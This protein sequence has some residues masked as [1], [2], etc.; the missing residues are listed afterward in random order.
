MY[1]NNENW[2]RKWMIM[3]ILSIRQYYFRLPVCVSDIYRMNLGWVDVILNL[4][5]MKEKYTHSLF[6]RFYCGVLLGFCRQKK[7]ENLDKKI[8]SNLKTVQQLCCYSSQ[9][10]YDIYPRMHS[11]RVENVNVSAMYKSIWTCTDMTDVCLQCV[12]VLPVLSHVPLFPEMCPC[13]VY[14]DPTGRESGRYQHTTLW[15]QRQTDGETVWSRGCGEER[16][17]LAQLNTR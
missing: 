6:S 1:C 14:P 17:Q 8:R 2:E 7:M 16:L 3:K 4:L 10:K 11:F 12:C 9:I 15:E 13:D 5:Q